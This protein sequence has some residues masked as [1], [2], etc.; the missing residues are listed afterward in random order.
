MCLSKSFYASVCTIYLTLVQIIMRHLF[1]RLQDVGQ[2][3]REMLL[4]DSGAIK[5]EKKNNKHGNIVCHQA[6]KRHINESCRDSGLLK[7]EWKLS[8]DKRRQIDGAHTEPRKMQQSA[9]KLPEKSTF[10]NK[11]EG[12]SG[13]EKIILAE[14]RPKRHI[15]VSAFCQ[16][17][18]L[19]QIISFKFV[20]RPLVK[21]ESQGDG[22]QL[23][24]YAMF[25][26]C[27]FLNL[28]PAGSE[29][30]CGGRKVNKTFKSH[31]TPR[32]AQ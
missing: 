26:L 11:E 20:C 19:T 13:L 3:K 2:L 27:I 23:M 21:S 5:K 24:G 15:S 31:L 8:S 6:A 16:Q 32:G 18:H 9:R 17:P 12:T 25:H 10:Y 1:V 28:G 22:G 7:S 30:I 14:I 4:K 29:L